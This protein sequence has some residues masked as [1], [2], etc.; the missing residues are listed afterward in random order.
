MCDYA[1]S[2]PESVILQAVDIA[3]RTKVDGVVGLGGGS[4]L[5]VAKLV[6]IL[7]LGKVGAANFA[8][9]AA[10]P[11]RPENLEAVL[12]EFARKL[13][14]NLYHD[15]DTLRLRHFLGSSAI[16]GGFSRPRSAWYAPCSNREARLRRPNGHRRSPRD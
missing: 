10:P 3:A 5:D 15:P 4:S 8:A 1:A 6:S 11:D 16:G 7:A 12:L 9:L 13:A 2:G 14:R